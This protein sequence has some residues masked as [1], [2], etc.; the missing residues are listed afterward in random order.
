MV[1]QLLKAKE[2]QIIIIVILVT[3]C[4]KNIRGATDETPVAV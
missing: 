3:E 2:I 1:E 4:V